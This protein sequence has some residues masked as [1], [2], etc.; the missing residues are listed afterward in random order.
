M[1]EGHYPEHHLLTLLEVYGAT[2]G[3]QLEHIGDYGTVR[4]YCRFAETGGS[5]GV[6]KQ[7][8]IA[9][10]NGYRGWCGLKAF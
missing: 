8:V 9:G 5:T 2:P 7:G 10:G 4:G 1:E 3:F 6:L